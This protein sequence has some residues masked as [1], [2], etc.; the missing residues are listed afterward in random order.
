MSNNR[1]WMQPPLQPW[2]KTR[3]D[4]Q[5]RTDSGFTFAFCSL[6]LDWFFALTFKIKKDV[7]FEFWFLVYWLNKRDDLC[8]YI[9]ISAEIDRETA[10]EVYLPLRYW[11]IWELCSTRSRA[12]GKPSGPLNHP[13]YHSQG[14]DVCPLCCCLPFIAAA[15]QTWSCL[16]VQPVCQSLIW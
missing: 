11:L 12:Q 2:I 8:I 4:G 6:K 9:L 10:F 14:S 5:S 7:H 13:K 3:Q 1:V 15:L 16:S